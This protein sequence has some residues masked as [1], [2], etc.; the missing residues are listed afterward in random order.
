MPSCIPIEL[1]VWHVS[2]SFEPH[3]PVTAGPLSYARK[4]ADCAAHD[5]LACEPAILHWQR[6]DSIAVLAVHAGRC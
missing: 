5:P 3:D 6:S 1:Q 2:M 4:D